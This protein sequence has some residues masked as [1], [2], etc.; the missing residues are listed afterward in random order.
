MSNRKLYPNPFIIDLRPFAVEPVTGIMLPDGIFDA[1]L[2]R[3][4]IKFYIRN[5]S[6]EKFKKIHYGFELSKPNDIKIVGKKGGVII[7]FLPFSTVLVHFEAD[8]TNTAPGE[9]ELMIWISGENDYENKNHLKKIFVTKT[10]YDEN[11]KLYKC[12]TG[13]AVLEQVFNEVHVYYGCEIGNTDY[14]GENPLVF[15]PVSV[16][17]TLVPSKKFADKFDC[18]PFEDPLPLWKLI[19]AIIAIIATIASLIAAENGKGTATIGLKADII[20]GGEGFKICKPY[21]G[22]SFKENTTLAGAL[23]AIASLAIAVALKHFRDPWLIGRETIVLKNNELIE[24]ELVNFSLSPYYPIK[25]GTPYKIATKWEYTA[26]TDQGN[27]YTINK[28]EDSYNEDVIEDAYVY[29]PLEVIGFKP[30]K[31]GI[32]VIKQK[33]PEII[34]KPY[35]IYAYCLLVSPSPLRKTYKI[36]LQDNGKKYDELSEDGWFTGYLHLEEVMNDLSRAEMNGEWT[37]YF[38]TQ[39]VNGTPNEASVETSTKYVGGTFIV[40]AIQK[41]EPSKFECPLDHVEEVIEYIRKIIVRI[42]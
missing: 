31:L 39:I 18:I 11:A 29:A 14:K 21:T 22:G 1:T 23:S 12:D 8:F 9:K 37:A 35:E 19:A 41:T 13:H 33:N 40:S 7:D 27:K 25:P 15:I 36:E 34:Y 16:S 3:L 38:F 20:N 5:T 6:G 28:T 30:I 24:K 26:L 4:D 10:T 42:V 17:T 32:K 2:G